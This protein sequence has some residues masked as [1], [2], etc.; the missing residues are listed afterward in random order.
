M[1]GPT[2]SFRSIPKQSNLILNHQIRVFF[3]YFFSHW[4]L[5]PCETDGFSPWDRGLPLLVLTGRILTGL[6]GRLSKPAE[7]HCRHTTPNLWSAETPPPRTPVNLTYQPEQSQNHWIQTLTSRAVKAGVDAILTCQWA[8][9]SP[10]VYHYV[11]HVFITFYNLS[12]SDFPILYLLT[13]IIKRGTW[14]MCS[15]VQRREA[16][17][18]FFLNFLQG[19]S[20]FKI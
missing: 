7:K 11:C 20:F 19:P 8:R 5:H 3:I 15:S 4:T 1:I 6:Y 2:F 13:A 17:M 16:L 10:A 12:K 14:M 9:Q 18:I